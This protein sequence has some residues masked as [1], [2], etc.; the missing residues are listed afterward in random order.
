MTILQVK[1]KAR[2]SKPR[3]KGRLWKNGVRGG[4]QAGRGRGSTRGGKVS[5]V[6]AP[7]SFEPLRFG[8][9]GGGGFMG[10]GGQI[11]SRGVERFLQPN[12]YPHVSERL[13]SR[14]KFHSWK[15][16]IMFIS[17]FCVVDGR[18]CLCCLA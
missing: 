12:L 8:A 13:P 6:R 16:L 7:T 1:V 15:C 10:R 9:R 3:Q 5:W 11:G 14:H 17:L 2:L 4:Y 18:K